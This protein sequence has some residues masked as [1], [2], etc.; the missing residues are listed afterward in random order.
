MSGASTQAKLI[1]DATRHNIEAS[2]RLF[3]VVPM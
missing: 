2:L 1:A 3:L